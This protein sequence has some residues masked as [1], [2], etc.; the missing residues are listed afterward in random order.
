MT[1]N[2]H[3]EALLPDHDGNGD[4]IL[5]HL[6]N[7]TVAVP[8][9][10][11]PPSAGGEL[12]EQTAYVFP[13]DSPVQWLYL[14]SGHGDLRRLRH[15]YPACQL[16]ISVRITVEAIVPLDDRGTVGQIRGSSE[17][18]ALSFFDPF[19]YADREMLAVD[20][21]Y[22]FS[23]AALALACSVSTGWDYDPEKGGYDYSGMTL[24]F[25]VSDADEYQFRTQV[26]ETRRFS[27]AAGHEIYGI[28]GE[29]AKGHEDLQWWTYS[30][31]HVMMGPEPQVGQ[32]VEGCLW[33][34]GH[35]ST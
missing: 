6:P 34:Q 24:L 22:T 28:R 26:W 18:T 31:P 11:F 30:L 4:R 5:D 9:V 29:F 33:L 13:A 14:M 8:K 32:Y 16:G 23:L 35:L 19:F 2:V 17:S 1:Y 27:T 7:A 25:P 12:K 10:T 20:Q 3:W 21:Q 15:A